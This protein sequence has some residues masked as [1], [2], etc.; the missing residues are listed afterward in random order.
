MEFPLI[1]TIFRPS[2]LSWT[3]ECVQD[4]CVRHH[5]FK[6]NKEKAARIP[7]Q[8]CAMTCGTA[9]R[10]IVVP[11]PTIKYLLG[12]KALDFSLDLIHTHIVTPHKEVEKL[13]HES[14]MIFLQD[15]RTLEK[16][17]GEQGNS[18]SSF[19][20]KRGESNG[21]I[22]ADEDTNK[23]KTKH[24]DIDTLN[25]RIMVEKSDE[26]FLNLESDEKYNLSIKGEL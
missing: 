1:N 4:K 2:E 20:N 12:T 21:E 5:Y 18:G 17:A 22:V 14:V 25:I 23:C 15:L 19:E 7:Y 24:C 6:D 3:Y 26:V 11:N 10:G 9:G 8:S 16:S 13:L